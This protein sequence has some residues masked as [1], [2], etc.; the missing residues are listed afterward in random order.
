MFLNTSVLVKT[1]TK[2][3]ASVMLL[4]C[5]S[6]LCIQKYHTIIKINWKQIRG[7]FL[8]PAETHSKTLDILKIDE[9][10]VGTLPFK[11]TFGLSTEYTVVSKDGCLLYHGKSS[12]CFKISS[13]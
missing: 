13:G 9:V 2:S 1:T 10:A 3:T 4:C 5:V 7:S 8:K 12:S 6:L 11:N